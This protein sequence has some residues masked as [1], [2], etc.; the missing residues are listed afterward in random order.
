VTNGPKK[1]NHVGFAVPNIQ[2]FLKNTAPLYEQFSRGPLITNDRQRVRQMFL[3]DG[4]TTIEFLEPL[5]DDSPLRGFLNKNRTGGLLHLALEVVDL[6][7]AIGRVTAAGGRLVVAPVP[8]VAFQER[9]IAFVFLG[10][11]ITELIEVPRQPLA[12]AP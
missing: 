8:D 7:A 9:R 11:Q 3:T 12:S 4:G 6:D 5:Q 1:I 2:T 10:G